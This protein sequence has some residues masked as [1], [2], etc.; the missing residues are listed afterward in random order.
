MVAVALAVALGVQSGLMLGQRRRRASWECDVK[1][2][3]IQLYSLSSCVGH[4]VAVLRD[5]GR[6]TPER[7]HSDVTGRESGK[8]LLWR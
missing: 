5:I 2:N 4:H 3:I 8:S 1:E 6:G 7:T